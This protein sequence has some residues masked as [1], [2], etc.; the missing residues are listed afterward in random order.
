[1]HIAS[2]A[3]LLASI[4]DVMDDT[5]SAVDLRDALV[6]QPDADELGFDPDDFE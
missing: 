5:A 3:N 6:Y 1:M 4:S 2:T